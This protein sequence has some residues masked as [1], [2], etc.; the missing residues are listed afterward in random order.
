MLT[1]KE[2]VPLS[3]VETPIFKKLLWRQNPRLNFLLKQMFKHD[4][5]L[6]IIEMTKERFVSPSL[7]SCN[8]CTIPFDLWMSRG[9]VDTFVHIVH[10]L[11]DNWEPCHVTIEFFKTI[12]TSRS[13]MVLQASIQNQIFSNSPSWLIDHSWLMNTYILTICLSL[14]CH[15]YFLTNQ[16]HYNDISL[17]IC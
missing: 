4:I 6:R 11:N 14:E 3:F 5:V 7:M 8:I 13:S 10:F 9:G 15:V 16:L 17:N 2:L 12:D 1:T